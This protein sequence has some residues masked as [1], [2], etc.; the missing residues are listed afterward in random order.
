MKKI[1]I[2]LLISCLCFTACNEPINSNSGW[3]DIVLYN[4]NIIT[5]DN[6]FNVYEAI[7]IK[8]KKIL[9]VGSNKVIKPLIGPHT[10]LFDLNGK[11]V[12]PGFID[13]HIHFLATIETS[14]YIDVKADNIKTF[15]NLLIKIKE[16]VLRT[17]S[18]EWIIGFGWDQDKI[19]WPE[20]RT[21]KWPTKEDLDKVAKNN[22]V[23]LYRIGG[24]SVVV[25]SLALKIANIDKNTKNPAGGEIVKYKNGELTGILK[26]T[27][28]NLVSQVIPKI[29]I[30]FSELEKYCYLALSNGLTNIEEA[31][32]TI[33]ALN[34]YKE[35]LQNKKLLIR[36]NALINSK[37]LDYLIENNIQSPYDVIDRWLRICGVK[38]FA[39]GA[40]G[41]RTAALREPYA[42]DLE[43]KGMLINSEDWFINMFTRAHSNGIQTATHSI[44]D[45]A[46]EIILSANYISYR[47]LGKK[48]GTYRDRIEH[49]QVLSPDLIERFKKQNMLASIQFSFWSSDKA[50]AEKR[51]GK[52]RLKYAYAW[53]EL[54][55]KNI[56]ISGGT[57]APVETYIPLEGLE[58][59][60]KD[61]NVPIKEAIKFY[62]YNAAYAS[63]QEKYLG[64]LE[65]GKIAD[66]IVLNNNIL[67]TLKEDISDLQVIMTILDGKIV[68]R[69]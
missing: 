65:K 4:G 48:L 9:N 17:N 47:N 19:L 67:K 41:E 5:V 54:L 14:K 28:I 12:L 10:I 56:L 6:K 8:N 52:E 51:L 20:K 25:N 33:N 43:N 2:L 69:Q 15:N 22:P 13:S 31:N 36:V 3:A 35:A 44:G 61:S 57:D 32:L 27:A 66:I 60:V 26:E 40:L 55:K 24:H 49:C 11:S 34:F 45:L 37:E 1:I 46:S 68:Y 38:F 62:T 16:K 21:Y 29:N 50:W 30:T 39:D 7:A 63:F 18:G 58:N 59:I 64:S 42:D 23:I 53:N